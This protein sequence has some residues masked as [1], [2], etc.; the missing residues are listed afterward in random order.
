MGRA[1]EPE[2]KVTSPAVTAW[3]LRRPGWTSAS[4]DQRA[5]A[6]TWAEFARWLCTSVRSAA[7]AAPV[8]D[9]PAARGKHPPSW[10]RKG[11]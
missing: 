11:S 8:W 2:V 10:A 4:L 3:P 9:I 7:P 5:G 1:A 6:S